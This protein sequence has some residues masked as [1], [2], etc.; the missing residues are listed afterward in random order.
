MHKMHSDYVNVSVFCL[1]ALH[2]IVLCELT[3][4]LDKA[5]LPISLGAFTF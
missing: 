2:I 3:D 1:N 4:S 5:L